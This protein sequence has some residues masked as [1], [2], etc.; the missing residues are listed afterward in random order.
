MNVN[1]SV[2][3]MG[4]T[5]NILPIVYAAMRQCYS[6]DRAADL[7]GRAVANKGIDGIPR[8]EQIKFVDNVLASGHESPIE[9]ISFTFALTGVSRSL[10]HQLVR[11]RLATYSQQSQRYVSAN[12]FDYILPPAI[13]EIPE[14]KAVF[15]KAMADAGNAY[16]KIQAILIENG[17]KKTANEDARFVLPNACETRIVLTMNARSLLHFF[18]LRCCKRAQWEIRIVANTMLAQCQMA[19][20]ELFRYAGPSCTRTGWCVEGKRG[21]GMRPVMP[22]APPVM[23]D[24][25]MREAGKDWP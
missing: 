18:N 19:A 17:Q 15:E 14:A 6:A 10:T 9:H 16:E 13:E 7:F 11:H 20:P 3:L 21:C 22:T 25:E 1:P 8:E 2:F 23:S 4:R 24:E 12:D 5:P